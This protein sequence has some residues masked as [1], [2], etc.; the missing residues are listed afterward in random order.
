MLGAARAAGCCDIVVV[1][2]HRADEVREAVAADDVRFVLQREQLG[3]GHALAQ[4]ADQ[5]EGAATVLV[6][7]GDVPLVRPETLRRLVAAAR[8]GWGALAVAE[9][10]RPGS[11]GRVVATPDGRRLERI[12][13]AA[14]GS[15]DEMAIRHVNA[16]IYALPAPEVFAA[17]EELTPDNAKGE[18]YL[19]DALGRGGGAPANMSR[20]WRSRTPV[21]PWAPTIATTSPGSSAP[22]TR[23]PQRWRKPTRPRGRT[24]SKLKRCVESSVMSVSRRSCLFSWTAYGAWSTEATTPPA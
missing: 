5:I 11:L 15:P 17:L 23:D 6:L 12:V 13:E 21:R 8:E 2:G 20:W 14:D 4:A 16:G 9:L 10:E 22:S 3:T 1:V 18:Y 24:R 19:T 7:S